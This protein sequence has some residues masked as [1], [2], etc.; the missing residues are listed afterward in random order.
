MLLTFLASNPIFA[1]YEK[2]S[3]CNKWGMYMQDVK[4]YISPYHHSLDPVRDFEKHLEEA[5]FEKHVCEILHRRFTFPSFTVL[6]RK[7]FLQ[8]FF[9]GLY[10]KENVFNI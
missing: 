3:R 8:F 6:K 7:Y 10:E 4:R 2:M 1:I 5:G 9:F